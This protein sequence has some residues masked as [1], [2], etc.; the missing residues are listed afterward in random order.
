MEAIQSDLPNLLPRFDRDQFFIHTNEFGSWYDRDRTRGLVARLIS[1]LQVEVE[2]NEVPPRVRPLTF[3]FVNDS[4]IREIIERD[5]RELQSAHVARCWKAV[6]VLAGGCIEGILYDLVARNW[7]SAQT[8]ATARAQSDVTR[9][10]LGQLVTVAVEAKL[11]P[12][13]ISKLSPGLKDYRNLVHPAVEIREKLSP[14]EEE[15]T[16]ALA[17]LHMLHRDVSSCSGA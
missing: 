13:G 3:A 12:P 5:Y 14:A 10:T 8:T 17:V 15:A 6:L 9:W 2:S 7:A 4:A 1:R 11:V 16:V